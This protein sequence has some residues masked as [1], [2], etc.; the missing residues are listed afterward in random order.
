MTWKEFEQKKTEY[1]LGT[2]MIHEKGQSS[3]RGQITGITIKDGKI[4]FHLNATRHE[5]YTGK[6]AGWG[7]KAETPRWRQVSECP[8]NPV[9][10]ITS[11]L[12]G[13]SPDR[14]QFDI[15]GGFAFIKKP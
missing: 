2:L 13:S 10:D 8:M 7:K 12:L 5:I 6:K 1:I 14:I 3:Y 15:P 11:S 4:S 9:F